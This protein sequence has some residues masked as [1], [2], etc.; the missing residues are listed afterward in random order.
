MTKDE[1]NDAGLY[2]DT[3]TFI[4]GRAYNMLHDGDRASL[5]ELQDG[6]KS[7]KLVIEIRSA[8]QMRQIAMAFNHAADLTDA[9]SQPLT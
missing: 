6:G 4:H 5:Y 2:T 9:Q 7:F 3:A 8:A 1:L